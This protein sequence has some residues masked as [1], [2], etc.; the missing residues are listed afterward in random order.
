MTMWIVNGIL[1]GLLI[2]LFVRNQRKKRLKRDEQDGHCSLIHVLEEGIALLNGKY[3]VQECNRAFMRI[4]GMAQE[5]LIHR[6][7]FSVEKVAHEEV[8]EKCRLLLK[9][10]K[11]GLAGVRESLSY[12]R[13]SDSCVLDITAAPM[14]NKGFVLIIK[15]SS[16]DYQIFKMG[17]D[18]IANASHELRTPITII[19]GFIETLRELPEVS[20]AMLE[21][22]FE[23]VLRSCNRM[24]DI[25]KNLLLLTDLDHSFKTNIQPVDLVALLDNCRH[26]LLEI[27]PEVQIKLITSQQESKHEVDSSL[28]ELAIMNLLQNAV[29]YSPSPANIQIN[30]KQ[31]QEECLI[32]VIDQGYGIPYENRPHIFNRFYS[33]NKTISRKL[34]GAGLGLSIVKNIIEKHHGSISVEDNP[35][36]GTIFTVSLPNS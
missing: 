9:Q 25:V 18:F 22:I 15:D 28:L 24:D 6:D 26:S 12:N 35:N 30:L 32:S 27:Y 20:D 36:G 2:V 31:Q 34:G 17:K 8:L 5:G 16:H 11:V 1:L 23:K 14:G 21:D 13:G 4:L 7:I 19:K 33:V 3:E 29:K 10:V